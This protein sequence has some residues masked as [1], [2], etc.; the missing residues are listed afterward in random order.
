[1]MATAANPC[2]LARFLD[3][4]E[5]TYE[6]ALA[7][8]RR[9][10]KAS[11]WMWYVFPQLA[12]LGRSEMAQRYALRSLAE[13]QA[14]LA[15]PVLG[16]RYRDC[17]AALQDLAPTTAEAVFGTVDAMKLWSSLTLFTEAAPDERLFQAAL[18]RWFGGARDEATLKLL[19]HG[20]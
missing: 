13:A 19:D 8:I 15:H 11:H 2:D 9:G 4:Q 20:R 12:G 7:E 1:M 6:R 16:A 18:D 3:A 5:S 17:V 14:Y 10:R